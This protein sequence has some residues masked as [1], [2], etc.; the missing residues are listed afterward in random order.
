M[1]MKEENSIFYENALE[2]ILNS[3]VPKSGET[4]SIHEAAGRIIYEDIISEINI[5]SFDNSAMDGFAIRHLET[6]GA[7]KSA[8]LCFEVTGEVQAGGKCGTD[9]L[10]MNTAKRIMTGAPVPQGADSVI[11]VEFTIEDEDDRTVKIFKEMKLHENIRFSGE[12]VKIGQVIIKKGDR[13]GSA[14]IGLLA[15][16]N[17]KELLAFKIPDVA[18]IS[19]GNE[20]VDIGE[21]IVKGQVRNTNAYSIISEVKKYRGNP[22]Y[23]GIAK[24]ELKI[25]KEMFN[26]AMDFDIIIST[27]GVS[28]GR[29]DFVKDVLSDLGVEILIEKINMKPGKP[30]VFGKKGDKLFFGLPGNP[31]STLVSFIEFV[32]P[33]LLKMTGA[34]KLKKPE[35]YATLD[36]EI[37]KKDG[38]KEFIRGYFYIKQN[39][40]HVKSTGPQGSG[41]L[42]SMSDANCLIV[43]PEN[44][45][46]C[47]AGN[48]VLVQL[49]EHEEID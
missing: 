40:L 34:S 24:D 31:V 42:R 12:D 32:R 33:A 21:E 18:I 5:P 1:Q 44:S 2:I 38:R 17:R 11:P 20:I 26:K 19:T 15:A 8:P 3:I 49:I 28:K 16:V 6:L 14:E 48:H 27:G 35:I 47:K 30:I 45:N 43:I 9:L 29:Y 10:E 13:L 36:N 25:T 46:G 4:V 41:I 37:K 23:I 39:N 22:H 7:T